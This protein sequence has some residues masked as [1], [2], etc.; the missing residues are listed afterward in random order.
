[1][2]DLLLRDIP[3]FIDRKLREGAAA[4]KRSLSDEAKA[5]L[6]RAL[7]APKPAKPVNA[8][9]AIRGGLKKEDLVDFEIPPRLGSRPPPDFV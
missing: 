1:M 6:T 2:G 8:W 7:L 3:P 9:D 5:L 4:N